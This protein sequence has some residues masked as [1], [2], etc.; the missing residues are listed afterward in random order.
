MLEDGKHRASKGEV[1]VGGQFGTISLGVRWQS[2]PPV[3]NWQ[4]KLTGK[5]RGS[6]DQDARQRATAAPKSQ[7]LPPFEASLGEAGDREVAAGAVGGSLG[8]TVTEKAKAK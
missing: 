7:H 2:S 3:R 1:C 4:Q 8:E 6:R 5:S